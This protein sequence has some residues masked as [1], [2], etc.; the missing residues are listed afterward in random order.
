[1]GS[2]QD[3]VVA[4]AEILAIRRSGCTRWPAWA[5]EPGPWQAVTCDKA[6][7]IAILS[8]SR[9]VQTLWRNNRRAFRNGSQRQTPI[10]VHERPRSPNPATLS[11]RRRQGRGVDAGCGNLQLSKAERRQD[12]SI[13]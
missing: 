1:M 10:P 11:G 12:L 6:M 2:T 8:F 5:R 7:R 4:A 9:L 13:T 3:G